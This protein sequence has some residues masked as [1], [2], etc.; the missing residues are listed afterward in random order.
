[1][2]ILYF[3]TIDAFMDTCLFFGYVLTN[4]VINS[5]KSCGMSAI[6]NSLFKY[7]K[8]QMHLSVCTESRD[9]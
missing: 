7:F 8:F 3:R 2:P 9:R 6:K 5:G 1:M 4:I